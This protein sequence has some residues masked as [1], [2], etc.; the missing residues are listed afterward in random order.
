MATIND[1][2]LFSRLAA[3]L[4]YVAIDKFR[5]EDIEKLTDFISAMSN[6]GEAIPSHGVDIRVRPAFTYYA[7]NNLS[8][9]RNLDGRISEGPDGGKCIFQQFVK[10]K[11]G[12]TNQYKIEK[13]YFE[14]PNAYHIIEY[15]LF[16]R[17][18]RIKYLT[19]YDIGSPEANTLEKFI[20]TIL[21]EP[22]KKL[23]DSYIED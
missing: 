15:E 18:Y 8:S 16:G 22:Y 3:K 20:I 9:N 11:V 7:I 12:D 2:E 6:P 4:K 13:E 10:I 1:Y 21:R 5:N 19:I 23:Y 17:A 14:S